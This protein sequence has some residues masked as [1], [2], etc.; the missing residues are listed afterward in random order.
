MPTKPGSGVKR[1]FI[2]PALLSSTSTVPPLTPSQQ[3]N[4]SVVVVGVGRLGGERKVDGRLELGLGG[5]RCDDRCDVVEDDDRDLG[6]RRQP[7]DVGDRVPEAD[8]VV[9]GGDR[10]GAVGGDR[11]EGIVAGDGEIG[12]A[13]VG[14]GVV[15]EHVHGDALTAGERTGDVVDGDRGDRYVRLD[16]LDRDERTVGAAAA[17]GDLVGE[18]HGLGGPAPASASGGSKLIAPDGSMATA[19]EPA[20]TSAIDSGSPSGSESLSSTSRSWMSPPAITV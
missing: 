10:H 9:R 12:D 4:V 7:V 2:T 11:E 3:A 6:R 13:P 20:S 15:G 19:S 16:D 18:R 14:I 5:E 8:G 17:V 1:T